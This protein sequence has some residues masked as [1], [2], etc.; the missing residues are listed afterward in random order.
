MRRC[1]M[2]NYVLLY[3][4]WLCLCAPPRV[5]PLTG[6]PVRIAR[7]RVVIVDPIDGTTNFVQGMPLSTVSVAVVHDG[8]VVVGVIYDP[9]RD[10]VFSAIAGRGARLN[11]TPMRVSSESELSAAVVAWE[12]I[13]SRRAAVPSF[14]AAAHLYSM[15][16]PV[17]ALRVLGSACLH[18]AWVAAGR[19]SAFWILD[20]HRQASH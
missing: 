2:A 14:R 3:V 16:T 12:T 19:L 10:E 15:A 11:G 7:G 8:V 1:V 5:C 13:H 20:L 9:Y 4:L 17:R 18:L 6:V